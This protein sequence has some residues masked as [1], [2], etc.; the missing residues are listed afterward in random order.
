MKL[1]AL[2]QNVDKEQSGV[3]VEY[4]GT[5]VSFLIARMNNPRYTEKIRKATKVGRGMRFRKAEDV[6]DKLVLEAVAETILLDWK[7][8]EDESGKPIPFS[9][10]AAMEILSDPQYRDVY[11]FILM[12]AS[13]RENFL[14]EEVDSIVK[15]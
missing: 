4:E 13:D 11:N 6:T 10:S 5:E 15:N 2:K 12:F 9:T 8:L 14:N 1:N 3:W 7:G